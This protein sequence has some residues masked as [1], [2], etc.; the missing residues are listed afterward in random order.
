MAQVP[1]VDF[2]FSG[3]NAA[4]RNASSYL[5]SARSTLSGMRD[6]KVRQDETALAEERFNQQMELRKQDQIFAQGAGQRQVDAEAAKELLA[7]NKRKSIFSGIQGM[8]N[9]SLADN[10]M[11]PET[12]A[13]VQQMPGYGQT[14]EQQ[15]QK[16]FSNVNNNVGLNEDLGLM[17]KNAEEY[18]GNN[19]LN[20]E[21]AAR[22][23]EAIS[24]NFS[25]LSPEQT[26]MLMDAEIEDQKQ[27]ATLIG[28]GFG[29]S[30]N[31]SNSNNGNSRRSDYSNEKSI[32]TQSNVIK[33][34]VEEQGINKSS[35]IF[36]KAFDVA[37]INNKDVTEENLRPGIQ[38]LEQAGVSPAVSLRVLQSNKVIVD[39]EY[40]NSLFS[41]IFSEGKPTLDDL[42]GTPLFDKIVTEGRMMMN[43]QNSG[44][45]QEQF[46]NSLKTLRLSQADSA[47][48][49]NQIL[50]GGAQASG[51]KAMRLQEYTNQFAAF[52]KESNSSEKDI[53]KMAKV[54]EDTVQ[55][56]DLID[57]N[58][59][60]V[61]KDNKATVVTDKA[62]STKI[63]SSLG[64]TDKSKINNDFD[65]MVQRKRAADPNNLSFKEG[66]K[67]Y[68]KGKKIF[69][70]K[71]A[72]R[73]TEENN[74]DYEITLNQ[75]NA[76]KNRLKL[77]NSAMSPNARKTLEK[78]L[79]KKQATISND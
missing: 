66:T 8:V 44:N 20:S 48:R 30:G 28:K 79:K 2:N 60:I 32:I 7:V 22:V 73:V 40:N 63:F 56:E 23:R 21:E 38:A 76:I 33:E 54:M 53:Q 61:V 37:R 72:E 62:S 16:I 50:S 31:N 17:L 42:V 57:T 41:S 26:Q 78:E 34:F 71:E 69:N 59:K 19:G 12:L 55:K 14:T 52:A 65:L 6:R 25:Q 43:N 46:G 4:T 36:S 13:M 11:T 58:E 45:S 75:I 51:T 15:R 3:S 70:N 68:A 5:D 47:K 77:P 67:E 1:K 10:Q 64:N 9:D 29:G 39:G 74:E 27:I 35:S 49:R 24:S 18:I